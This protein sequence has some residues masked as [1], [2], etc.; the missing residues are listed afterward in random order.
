MNDFYK[1]YNGQF[2]ND[3]Q[4]FFATIP[5]RSKF[6]DNSQDKTAFTIQLERLTQN[7]DHLDFLPDD[8]D[9]V[10][11][12]VALFFTVLVDEVCFSHFKQNYSAFK[13]LTLYPK[14]IGNCPGGCRFHL[15]PSDIFFAMNKYDKIKNTK[16]QRHLNFFETFSEAA[17][18]MEKE[19]KDFFSNLMTTINGNE[20]WE[21]CTKE[22]PYRLDKQT[23]TN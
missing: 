17:P 2:R 20:F 9:R 3:L 16:T 18:V 23:E 21:R 8:K 5:D 1:Y 12:G 22:F 14:F 11:F 4:M 6:H 10:K 13:Q 7:L 19:T 15:H